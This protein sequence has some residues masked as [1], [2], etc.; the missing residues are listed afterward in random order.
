MVTQ[1]ELFESP[2][3]I[4]LDI[5]L[6]GW[7]KSEICKR[8][9]CTPEELLARTSDGA[10]CIENAKI[11]SDEQHATFARELQSALRLRVGLPNTY[12]EL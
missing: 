10:A 7:M 2:D 12:F 6:C 9:V 1:V 5:F 11:N 4:P 3:R 8:K